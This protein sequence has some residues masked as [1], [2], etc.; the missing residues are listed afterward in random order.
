MEQNEHARLMPSAAGITVKCAGSVQAQEKYPQEET[1]DTKEGVAVHWVIASVLGE[2][3][4]PLGGVILTSQYVGQIAPNG[5]IITEEM[6]E[7]ADEYVFDI[8]KTCNAYGLLQSLRIEQRTKAGIIHVDNWGTP[9]CSAYHSAGNTLYL[10]DFKYGHQYVD[11]YE[12]WQLINYAILLTDGLRDTTNIVMRIVQPRCFSA[13]A[14]RE[15]SITV[16]ELRP[17]RNR[18]EMA[19]IEA[20]SEHP[21]IKSGSHCRYCSARH[22]CKAALRSSEASMDFALNLTGGMRELSDEGLGTLLNKLTRALESIELVKSGIEEAATCRLR[23]G[24][25]VTGWQLKEKKG[26]TI[27]NRPAAEIIE[28]GKIFGIDLKKPDSVITPKQAANKGID[29]GV[30]NAYSNTPSKGLKLD[31]DDDTK[32]KQV[33]TQ[34]RG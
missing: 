24:K 3:L 9:D 34:P 31:K 16:G 25:H 4:K 14:V 29:G 30:I 26:R 11:V 10:W 21:T 19:F 32:A 33:F 1:D 15:W 17:Y 20:L 12:C 18:L 27:W 28:L 13:A 23:A 22:A 6:V 2:Y 7:A 8:L 5:V